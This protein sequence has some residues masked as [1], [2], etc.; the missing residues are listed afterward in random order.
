LLLLAACAGTAAPPAASPPLPPLPPLA[1]PADSAAADT[2][3]PGVVHHAFVIKSAP[4]A[5]H[6]L[7]VDRS[8]CWSLVA[9][10][11]EGAAVGR[12]PTSALIAETAGDSAHRRVVAG[13]VNADFF[14]F[15]P[16]GVPLGAAVHEGR[17]ITGPVTRPVLAIDSAGRPWIGT[18]RVSGRVV[19]GR[20]TVPVENWNR[21]TSIGLAYFD[22]RY[23]E[24]MDTAQGSLR[25][26]LTPGP[27]PVVAV[28]DSSGG[29]V[30]IPARGAILSL[31]VSAPPALRERLLVA[32]LS[33]LTFDAQVALAPFHP[34][35]AVGGFPVLVRD[36]VEVAD[37]DQAGA[38]T[39]A[40]VRHPRTIVGLA[41][42]G[43]MVFLVT[44]DGCQ[45]GY[46]AGMTLRESAQ[47]LRDLGATDAINLDGGGSTSLV[48]RRSSPAGV[49]YELANRPSDREGE[50]PVA[51]ALAVVFG[52]R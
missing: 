46:S 44:V 30:A 13:G 15:T 38:A 16:P 5:I 41:A 17:V 7:D 10:K 4:W 48:L 11:A 29:V 27:R 8:A 9:L 52:C 22:R 36:S 6:V 14:S 2:I 19:A 50:R 18:L 25:M 31:G 37:L 21:R 40:P 43:R 1:F 33:H 32:A 35:E 28:I 3:A 20:D 49:R 47:L 45:A 39:F 24:L 34:L 12:S 23:G 51:N 26:I 42:A